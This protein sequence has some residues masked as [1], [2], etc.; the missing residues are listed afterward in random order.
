MRA[1]RIMAF[2]VLF[3]VVGVAVLLG[4]LWLDH[5]RETTLPTPTGPFAVGRRTYVWSDAAQAQL[6]APQLGTRRELLAWVWYPAASRQSSQSRQ[7]AVTTH[8]ISTFFDVYLKGHPGRSCGASR[9]IWRSNM[10]INQVVPLASGAVIAVSLLEEQ[11]REVDEV[12]G[13]RIES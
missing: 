8:C 7:I 11:R 2:V 6:M 4:L 9:G 10:S 5:T 12:V 3:G 13:P 1:I